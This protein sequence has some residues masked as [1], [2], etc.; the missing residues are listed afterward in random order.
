MKNPMTDFSSTFLKARVVS[1]S[2]SIQ[3]ITRQVK[4][5]L[6]EQ[7]QRASTPTLIQPREQDI[8]YTVE[9]HGDD[10]YITTNA[11][12]A[13]DFKIVKA[14]VITP[15]R[16]HWKDWVPHQS[17]VNILTFIPYKEYNVRLV[18][19][20]ALPTIVVSTL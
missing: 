7:M 11:D 18:R 1:L 9:H 14:P 10:F 20:D 17:G 12:N 6:L 5:D 13:V 3:A 15:D 16:K 8:E 2:S 19:N 4:C